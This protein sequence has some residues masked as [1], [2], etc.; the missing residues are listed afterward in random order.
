MAGDA[1]LP[2]G[3]L[4]DVLRRNREAFNA[5][6]AL[7][8]R[9]GARVDGDAFLRHLGTAVDP[10]LRPIAAHFAERVES[11][12]L[13]LYE[14]SL[15]LF[16]AA[17]L[18]PAARGDAVAAVWR[19][20]LPAVPR[21]LAR[22][23]RR[24]AASLSNAAHNLAQ[25]DGARPGEWL[26]RMAAAGPR[27]EDAATLLAAGQVA[28]WRAGCAQYR[29]GALKA[30]RTL[31]HDVLVPV[32]F[33][34]DDV[35]PAPAEALAALD[36]LAKHRWLTPAEALAGPVPA[37]VRVVRTAGAFRGFGGPFLRP[38]V[39][40]TRGPQLIVSDGYFVWELIADAAGC[41]FHR[42][43]AG[44]IPPAVKTGI[45]ALAANG[46]VQWEQAAAHFPQLA[47]ASS[48]AFDGQTLA[49]TQPA[50]HHVFLVARG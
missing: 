13:A 21:P 45:V 50:S 36:T 19:E 20:L 30:A 48:A 26:G 31:P 43:T 1:P 46:H 5:R 11:S 15:E 23:A 7:A 47:D 9:G 33:N 16:A 28:A 25:T 27:C 42:T 8:R 4:A 37:R 34:A 24:V 35:P 49:V 44:A 29:A 14:L 41:L 18:G 32:L 10:I 6:F 39:V 12:A 3:P 22:D 17:V 2:P 38:P 40:G